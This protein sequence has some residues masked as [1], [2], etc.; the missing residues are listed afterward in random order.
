MGQ[1][2]MMRQK[3]SGEGQT[4]GGDI[5]RKKTRKEKLQCCKRQTEWREK[6]MERERNWNT[7]RTKLRHIQRVVC[8]TKQL[9]NSIHKLKHFKFTGRYFKGL[10]YPNYH[11]QQQQ[12]HLPFT[13]GSSHV[14][15]VSFPNENTAISTFLKN[16][17]LTIL[18]GSS[19]VKLCWKLHEVTL[20]PWTNK[21]DMCVTF[22]TKDSATKLIVWSERFQSGSLQTPTSCSQNNIH[23]TKW[24][25][26]VHKNINYT[27]SVSSH[28]LQ[29]KQAVEEHGQTDFLNERSIPPSLS[30]QL[31]FGEPYDFMC[32]SSIRLNSAQNH[33]GRFIYNW[34][35][36]HLAPLHIE[37]GK[38]VFF[39][40]REK[41]NP[42]SVGLYRGSGFLV[43]TVAV[44][45]A[46]DLV[47]VSALEW[48]APWCFKG[49]LS[50]E[51][52]N[53]SFSFLL[54]GHSFCRPSV[55]VALMK[56][57]GS[58]F[59]PYLTTCPDPSQA[60][61]YILGPL[62]Q[63]PCHSNHSSINYV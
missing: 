63:G 54:T 6:E 21:N 57:Y 47:L 39:F 13:P 16:I 40:L 59:C 35:Q 36:M 58:T 55:T 33:G 38:S 50:M 32:Q 51:H 12:Q 11:H 46:A 1:P 19:W 23:L 20:S 5:K 3:K 37:T 28:S 43:V 8:Q 45:L 17:L 42:Y 4:E 34:K 49:L 30:N 18:A 60:P 15:S 27:L 26:A 10:V 29:A 7:H 22:P 31:D 56:K 14:N 9:I 53:Y 44:M 24:T 25:P 52:R 62:I 41:K 2:L 61:P 48:T